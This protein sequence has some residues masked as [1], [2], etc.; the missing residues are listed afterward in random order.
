[1]SKDNQSAIAES[2]AQIQ[3]DFFQSGARAASVSS[4]QE[5]PDLASG[6]DGSGTGLN[7][8]NHLMMTNNAD[9]I[10]ALL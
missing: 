3:P 2:G 5:A 9:I 8:V 4:N 1:M 10:G 7:S 6:L